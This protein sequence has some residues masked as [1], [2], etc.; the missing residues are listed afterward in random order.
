MNEKTR[1]SNWVRHKQTHCTKSTRNQWFHEQYACASCNF[2][3]CSVHNYICCTQCPQN[4]REDVH[5]KNYCF[6]TPWHTHYKQNAH[7]PMSQLLLPPARLPL[8]RWN[9]ESDWGDFQLQQEWNGLRLKLS[10][11]IS[12]RLLHFKWQSSNSGKWHM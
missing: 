6:E 10:E 3:S 1:N 12:L 7:C 2:L 5:N 4:A 11:E 8:V 9:T